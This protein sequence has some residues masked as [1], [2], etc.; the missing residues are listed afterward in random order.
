MEGVVFSSWDYKLGLS[1]AQS[2]A[3]SIL[4]PGYYYTNPLRDAN[5]NIVANGLTNVL[6]SGIV[7]PWLLPG[8]SQTAEA[9]AAMQSA[10]AQGARLFDGKS[11]LRQ[12]DGTIS[13]EVWKLPA[14]AVALAAG[15]DVRQETYQFLDG[16]EG[17]R[18]VFQAPF[19]ATFPKVK[20]DVKA[21]FAE[22][23]VPIVKGL[24]ATLAVRHDR[25]S[26]FGGTTN[27]KLSLK[28]TP[29][30][31]LLFRGSYNTGFR[32]PSFFQLYGAEGESPIPGNIA[33]PVL[34][35]GGPVP[36]SDPSL[37]QIRPLAREGGNVNLKPETSKQWSIGFV[38]APAD[39][40]NF[41]ADLWQ[42]KR[43][44]LIYELTPQEVVENFSTSR[45]PG[46]RQRRPARRTG[47]LHPR[48]F[49]QRRWRHHARCRS[50][51]AVQR[52]AGGR[53]VEC[54]HR[55]HLHR[56]P[57]LA[58]LCQPA[59]HRVRRPMELTRSVCAL[60]APGAS[61]L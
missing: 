57:P 50:E 46:A 7:N 6:G 5:D 21:V 22:V 17:A 14:G 39:W 61:E 55:R 45:E 26:D 13:G 42:I 16:S 38:A 8:E 3:E 11:T 25:Y 51:P 18:P 15:F 54:R 58:C 10:S 32:A 19:D 27:P 53:H 24:E 44:D 40:V 49:R 41:S 48:R 4:G 23:A 1:T 31:A 2:K 28:W 12:F 36:G 37:C 56:Q 30:Q 59:L 20:R 47:R 33:D 60:E 43:T 35:P 9:L 29:T 52:Q 34:C